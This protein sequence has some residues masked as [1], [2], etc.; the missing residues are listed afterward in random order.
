M[1]GRAPRSPPL[2]PNSPDDG[3][4]SCAWLLDD[5]E[6]AGLLDQ[7]EAAAGVAR[8]EELRARL[9][10]EPPRDDLAFAAALTVPIGLGYERHRLE[11]AEGRWPRSPGAGA[12]AGRAFNRRELRAVATVVSNVSARA[13]N[14]R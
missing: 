13:R 1:P 6:L 11:W 12:D 10:P 9:D 2:P 5:D 7:A 8:F 4:A 14:P 3:Q